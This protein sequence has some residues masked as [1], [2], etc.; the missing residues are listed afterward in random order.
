MVP[1]FT[2]CLHPGRTVNDPDPSPETGESPTL[3]EKAMSFWEHLDELRGTL[4][5]SVI[6]VV[7]SAGLV[8]WYL[9]K[10]Y[11]LLM[12]PFDHAVAKYPDL[13]VE[14]GTG[15]MLQG[16]NVLVQTC[17]YG[18][19]LLAAPF[20]LYFVAQFVAP[21]LTS[22]EKRAVLPLCLA[23]GALLALGVA[24][25]FFVIVPSAVQMTIEINRTFDWK[26]YWTVGDYYSVLIS[27]V[28]GIGTLFQMPLIVVLLVWL[29][30]TSTAF[31]RRHR[32]HVIVL[33]FIAAAVL[34]PTGDPFMQTLF[35][36]PLYLLFEVALLVSARV[37]RNRERSHAAAFVAVLALLSATRKRAP[38][39][40]HAHPA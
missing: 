4:I 40:S 31:L 32:R 18:G 16:F 10:F 39:L 27:T 23:S 22:R 13:T 30:L 1:V 3:R 11:S 34:T 5:K 19:L 28:L 7:L 17:L 9:K 33:L 36:L 25:A 6:A 15:S 14:L 38:S 2:G 29:G 20:I 26:F 24:F 37:E 12:W 21:A 35:G 8:G